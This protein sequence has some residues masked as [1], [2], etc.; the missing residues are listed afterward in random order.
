[1]YICIQAFLGAL[2]VGHVA[3]CMEE[4]WT[5]AQLESSEPAALDASS[6]RNALLPKG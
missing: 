2:I 5:L 1:M 4:S 6:G 3:S